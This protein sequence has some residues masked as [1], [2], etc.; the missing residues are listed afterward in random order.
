MM[1]LAQISW[2]FLLTTRKRVSL[3]DGMETPL[4]RV[5]SYSLVTCTGEGGGAPRLMEWGR[6][7][8]FTFRI[9]HT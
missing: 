8:G 1:L 9:L 7:F 3:T 5:Q 6:Q 2:L 4:A